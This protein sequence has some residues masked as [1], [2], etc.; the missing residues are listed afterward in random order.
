MKKYWKILLG[1]LLLGVAALVY[2]NFYRPAKA[3]FEVQRDQLN[4][5]VSALQ[6]TVMENRRYTNV[7]EQIPDALTEMD[8]KRLALYN[9]FPVE[10][11]EEDQIMYILYLEEVFG[12]EI[13]FAFSHPEDIVFLSDGS[14]VQT[15]TLTV[16][17]ECTYDEF[18]EMI[19]YLATDDKITSVY[20]ARL[21]YDADKD[22]ASGTIT[23]M[24]YLINS[25]LLEYQKPEVTEPDTGK[26][27]IFTEP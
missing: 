7:H 8:E 5:S 14:S 6:S 4:V 16:N 15:L 22:V 21:N 18:Q 13:E 11:K 3:E 9:K 23:I 2:M 27:N 19:T 26:E 20:D 10:M 24:R 1:I 12:T 25:D 17:Y